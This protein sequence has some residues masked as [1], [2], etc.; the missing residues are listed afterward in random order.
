[1]APGSAPQAAPLPAATPSPQG[2]TASLPPAVPAP[3]PTDTA[4]AETE[5]TPKPKQPHIDRSGQ[6]LMHAVALAGLFTIDKSLND[7]INQHGFLGAQPGNVSSI[8]QLG[9][10][11]TDFALMEAVH[12][13]TDNPTTLAATSDAAKA[14]LN[15][16][17]NVQLL[18]TLFGRGNPNIGAD[19]GNFRGPTLTSGHDSFP[20]GHT[21]TAFAMATALGH[22]YPKKKPLFYTLAGVVGLST[23]AAHIHWASDVYAG[24]LLGIWSGEQT[25]D[26]K[27][28]LLFFKF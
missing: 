1:P 11:F 6:Y 16:G 28:N 4:V 25:V 27:P 23:L 22:Y 13:T 15:A 5:P 2:V 3:S 26:K 10:G 9:E 19:Q 20:S 18:K 12:L 24:A 17:I 7:S 21:A 14:V 8:L